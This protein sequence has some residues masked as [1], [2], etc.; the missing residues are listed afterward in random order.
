MNQDE[1]LKK[2]GSELARPVVES[3]DVVL[4]DVEQ[5]SQ[6][7]AL[8]ALTAI[9][10]RAD[11]LALADTLS[12]RPLE[13][14]RTAARPFQQAVDETAAVLKDAQES[15]GDVQMA[16]E[17]LTDAKRRGHDVMLHVHQLEAKIAALRALPGADTRDLTILAAALRGSPGAPD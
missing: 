2:Y 4:R 15:H 9:Y 16:R 1:A 6:K 5:R 17:A 7:R 3:W 8:D 14:A 12:G 13:D 10:L 11:A